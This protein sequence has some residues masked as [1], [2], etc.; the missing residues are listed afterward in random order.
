MNERPRTVLPST[1]FRRSRNARI[2]VRRPRLALSTCRMSPCTK[3]RRK[4]R[5]VGSG[6]PAAATKWVLAKIGCAKI[7][8]IARTAW[9]ERV[10]LVTRVTMA[11]WRRTMPC[12]FSRFSSATVA[13]EKRVQRLEL[14]MQNRQLHEPIQRLP[15]DVPLPRGHGLGQRVRS[16]RHECSLVD[17][18]AGRADPVGMRRNSPGALP[19]P[20]APRSSIAC[21]SRI[22][23]RD[24]GSLASS[25]SAR[26][27][28]LR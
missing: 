18:A 15:V 5:A 20:R 25:S 12:A 2:P 16:H 21:A 14:C 4:R 23:R 7:Q 27:R 26:R 6:M 3:T 22:T 8:S 19:S 13:V 1:T 28:A 11:S 24:K 9:C 17:G 10:K